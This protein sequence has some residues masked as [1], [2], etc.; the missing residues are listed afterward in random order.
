[1]LYLVLTLSFFFSMS[2]SMFK[3]PSSMA[4][5]IVFLSGALVSSMALTSSHW[6]SYVLFLVYVG[7]L[8]VMFIYVCLVS[9]NFPFKLNLSRGVLSLGVSLLLL[10][11]VSSPELK[12]VLGSN[13]WG[14]GS[15]LLDESNL[16]LFLFLA[17]LLLL[18]LLVVVRSSGTGTVK[19]D[20]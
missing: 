15:D 19:I 1:M 3:T 12:S 9:S 4:A 13:N 20:C 6:F 2:L 7:G 18:M 8:L 14:A 17:V 5:A 16:S 11:S 10:T